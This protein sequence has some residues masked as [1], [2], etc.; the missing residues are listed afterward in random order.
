MRGSPN[1]TL[2][3]KRPIVKG[4][5]VVFRTVVES[6]LHDEGTNHSHCCVLAH[7]ANE[8]VGTRLAWG[9][10]GDGFSSRYRFLEV[11]FVDHNCVV[12]FVV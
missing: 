5:W 3:K 1:K 2:W 8:W 6:L 12:A 11:D 10:E 9:N 7:V 4:Q